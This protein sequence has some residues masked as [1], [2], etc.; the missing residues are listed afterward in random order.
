MEQ[1]HQKL[2][3]V[4]KKKIGMQKSVFDAIIDSGD[5]FEW[6]VEACLHAS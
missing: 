1:K 2:Y 3:Q 4:V 6:S 5:M